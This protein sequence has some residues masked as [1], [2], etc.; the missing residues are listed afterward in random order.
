MQGNIGEP[1]EVHV[2][3]PVTG[4]T[5]AELRQGLKDFFEDKLQM[6]TGDVANEDVVHIRR[7]R[8]RR[9][10]ESL[11]EVLVLFVDIDTRDSVSSYARNLAPYRDDNGKPCLLYTSPSPRD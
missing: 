9:G 3:F 11:E 7:V 2:F 10:K 6:P 1:E 5:D 4:V 8:V